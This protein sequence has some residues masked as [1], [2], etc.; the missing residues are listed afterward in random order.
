VPSEPTFSGQVRVQLELAR[1]ARGVW[2]HG[3][4]LRVRRVSLEVPGAEPLAATWKPIDPEGLARVDFGRELPAGST[5]ALVFEYEA[6]W[7][8]RLRGAYRVKEG[9]RDYVFTQFEP[10]S[11]RAA[12]PSFDEPRFK[13]TFDVALRVPASH[14]A[15][16][17]APVLS[18]SPAADG[19]KVVRFARTPKLSTY[20]VA[21]AVGPFDVAVAPDIA[22]T[23]IRR[24]KVPLRAFAAKGKGALLRYALARTRELLNVIERYFGVP[25][26]FAKLDLIAVPDFAAGAMENA[27]AITFREP[28]L[29][30]DERTAP[31][32][33]QRRVLSVLA[34]EL[35]HQW[36][37]DLVTMR[38]FDDLWLN[39]A[40]AAWLTNVAV[41]LRDPSQGGVLVQRKNAFAAMT[42]D[43][44][45]SARRVR[46]PIESHSDIRNA[47]DSITYS[48]G[49]AVLG[50]FERFLGRDVFR[51]GLRRYLDAHRFGN[52][53]SDEFFA[54]LSTAAG[55]DVAS[56][57]G[58]FVNQPGVPLID[59]DPECTA[60]GTRVRLRQSRFRP[61]GIAGENRGLWQIPVCLR[62]ATRGP[63]ALVREHCGLL[64]REDELW[65]LPGVK[66]CLAWLH[67]NA[68]GAG[69]YRF[70][71][72][73]ASW[74]GL[75]DALPGLPVSEQL[76]AVDSVRAAFEAGR[77][78]TDDAVKTLVSLLPTASRQ[79]FEPVSAFLSGLRTGTR[80]AETRGWIES[81]VRAKVRPVLA[82]LGGL[83]G[84][85][86]VR[87]KRTSGE[88]ADRRL[89]HE[90]VLGSLAFVG[91]DPTLRAA[92]VRRTEQML[93]DGQT[94]PRISAMA[95][96]VLAPALRAAVEDRG[97]EVV[98]RLERWV[99]S[100][101]PDA[102][103]RSLVVP[104]LGF[105][106]DPKMSERVLA[107]AL[108]PA[109]RANELLPI[110]SGQLKQ[111]ETREA[112]WAWLRNSFDAVIAKLPATH[113]VYLTHIVR[114]F[115]TAQRAQEV[116]AFYTPRVQILKSGAR[117]IQSAVQSIRVCA[118]IAAAH[119]DESRAFFARSI[120]AGSSKPGSGTRPP[121]AA[122]AH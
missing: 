93:G 38:W 99:R 109:L 32:G 66:G 80:S 22:P 91:R 23:E 59:V 81:F 30:V 75:R 13:A 2:M 85:G 24:A 8:R 18:E 88:D 63:K 4:G 95:P 61:L 72:P 33:L 35:A 46:Q 1:A 70:S 77:I 68:D 15:V 34:H 11:A 98:P 45:P 65:T 52:A 12:F 7:N 94:P 82:R 69:Y 76:A 58:T 116:E 31:I 79:V 101:G 121:G 55:R 51:R 60:D 106:T 71:L 89:Y 112:A 5:A 107:L 42:G 37:G 122:T 92:L 27:G 16:S 44:L 114:S 119:E 25:Y 19:T 21:F 73:P 74:A 86:G 118:A 49:S 67:P 56:A 47:F 57:M 6:D 54:A 48:K 78:R 113:R 26:P 28:L 110:L 14:H 115:C 10:L 87:G 9:G 39:E 36:F 102:S 17:N 62:F 97:A 103:I 43:S 120:G 50:M 90:R 111:I 41:D 84:P 83:D 100:G 105:A 53:T 64:T 104:A 117:S 108:D 29:L 3:R 20:L 96:E 40:F